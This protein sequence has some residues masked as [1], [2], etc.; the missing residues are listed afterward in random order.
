MTNTVYTNELAR[1]KKMAAEGKIAEEA[2]GYSS[3]EELA[4]KVIKWRDSDSIDDKRLLVE[5]GS[6]QD[7][8]ELVHSE[9]EWLREYI[10]WHGKERDKDLDILV[11]DED[12]K[13]RE[14]V[15]Y[16][17]RDKDLDILVHD[18]DPIVREAVARVGR[19]K[20]L[21][22]LVYDEDKWV[23]AAVAENGRSQDLNILAYDED[24]D[25]RKEVFDWIGAKKVDIHF[26]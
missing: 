11:H 18:H 15:A 1:L 21:D 2:F 20:D 17:K 5:Y 26:Y 19:Y 16:K 8:D 24:E 12:P 23:R 6:D 22:I 3:L 9:S 14:Q 10:V 13:V 25:V 4:K 7:L